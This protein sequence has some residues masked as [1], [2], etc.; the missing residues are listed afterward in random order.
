[1]FDDLFTS[2]NDLHGL[3]LALLGRRSRSAF[4]RLKARGDCGDDGLFGGLSECLDVNVVIFDLFA[5]ESNLELV[6]FLKGLE[7][8]REEPGFPGIFKIRDNLVREFFGVD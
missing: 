4:E 6:G 7:D 5:N 2:R 8:P 3:P 1:M